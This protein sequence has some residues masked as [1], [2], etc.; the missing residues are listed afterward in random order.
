M[1]SQK[2]KRLPL[3]VQ[4]AHANEFEKEKKKLESSFKKKE[5]PF[6]LVWVK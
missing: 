2:L 6:K 1:K 4:Q 5:M 3:E